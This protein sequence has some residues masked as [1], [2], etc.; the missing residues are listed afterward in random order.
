MKKLSTIALLTAL[1]VSPSLATAQ[2]LGVNGAVGAVTNGAVNVGD[3]NANAQVTAGVSADVA[4][5]GTLS[6]DDLLTDLGN[7]DPAADI[8]AAT[9]ATAETTINIVEV[10]GL[11][12][13]ANASATAVADARASNAARLEAIHAAITANAAIQAKLTASGHDTDDVV[14]VKADAQGALWVYV[15][16][17]E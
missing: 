11:E 8:S 1:V 14:A 6:L 13:S 5:N 15:D 9:S 7:A 10:A 2:D 17:A 16:E 12:G 3:Q 4:A